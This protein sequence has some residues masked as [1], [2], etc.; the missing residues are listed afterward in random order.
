M[1]FNE[2]K[3]NM[4]QSQL[5]TWD[6][7]DQTVLDTF[8]L[9][10]R[11]DFVPKNYKKISY[12]DTEIPIGSNEK[13]LNPKLVGRLIQELEI[14]RSDQV[15]QIGTGTGYI[16]ALLGYLGRYVTS[17]EINEKINNCALEN[18]NKY[19]RGNLE[20]KLGNGFEA[21]VSTSAFDCI[22]LA[23]SVTNTSEKLKH[24]LSQGGR[25]LGVIGEP[26]LMTATLVTRLDEKK[27]SEISLFETYAPRLIENSS[28]SNFDF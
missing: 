19:S 22:L 5:R 8:N 26:P 7:L 10:N 2:A 9:V 18:L 6:V 28:F 23:G 20:L 27:F 24:A 25:L 11:Q 15:L 17:Y 3:K 4:I 1:N 12:A 21:D 14:K 16:T 13:M